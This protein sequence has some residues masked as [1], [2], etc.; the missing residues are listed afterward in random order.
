MTYHNYLVYD[1]HITENEYKTIKTFCQMLDNY[2]E[3]VDS[4]EEVFN[5]ISGIAWN[6]NLGHNKITIAE[7]K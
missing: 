4:Y 3:D 2:M 1:I 7:E 5:F 6:G